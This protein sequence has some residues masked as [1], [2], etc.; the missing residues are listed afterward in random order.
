MSGEPHE[1]VTDL[2]RKIGRRIA[3]CRKEAG[4][5]R[6]EFAE[7][8][9]STE[10]E[11]EAWET[12]N[13][14]VYPPHQSPRTTESVTLRGAAKRLSSASLCLCMAPSPLKH[15]AII[16]VASGPSIL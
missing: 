10:A 16:K 15:E 11:I 3:L 2:D 7:Q 8:I 1:P 14:V 13:A 6:A 9:D 12:G 5:T 4:L